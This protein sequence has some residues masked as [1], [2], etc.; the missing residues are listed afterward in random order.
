MTEALQDATRQQLPAMQAYLNECGPVQT[1][2]FKGVTPSGVD[3]Y[4]V[5]YRSGKQSQ[6]FIG[7]GADGKIAGMLVR[8]AF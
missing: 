5:T 1:V 4:L 8:E 2:E 3:K 7:L 6:W